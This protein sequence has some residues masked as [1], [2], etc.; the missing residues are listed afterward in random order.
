MVYRQLLVIDHNSN[1]W[2]WEL[3][4]LGALNKR[5]K[6]TWVSSQIRKEAQQVFYTSITWQTRLLY[7]GKGHVGIAD[8]VWRLLLS[9]EG[10]SQVCNLRNFRFRFDID[11]Y[12][13]RSQNHLDPNC[14][15]RRLKR[16]P[17]TRFLRFL[18]Q[19]RHVEVSWVDSALTIP[20]AQKQH[21]LLQPFRDVRTIRSCLIN[22]VGTAGQDDGIRGFWK[23]SDFAERIK[24]A[25]AIP[26]VRLDPHV[27][28]C[29]F[30]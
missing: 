15:E 8:K 23:P 29:R 2:G 28:E 9:L 12:P 13:F 3:D 24:E 20:W 7:S 27:T 1:N 10:W 21:D 14:W 19:L 17:M 11:C 22:L 5:H 30:L 26:D 4:R 6:I 18:P 25:T 16:L